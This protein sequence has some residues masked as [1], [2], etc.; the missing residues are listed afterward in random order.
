MICCASVVT[1]ERMR[2]QVEGDFRAIKPKPIRLPRTWPFE[3]QN[4]DC[5]ARIYKH[6]VSIKRK[7]KNQN[8]AAKTDEYETFL[9]AYYANGKRQRRRFMD[10]AKAK[11]EA[12]RITEQKAQGAL[13]AAA[14]SPAARVALENALA[15]LA[16]HEGTQ[17]AQPSR[18]VEIVNDYMAARAGLPEGATLT[19]AVK[20]FAA[21]HPANRPRKTVAE[22]AE[23]F[24]ADRR[25]AGCSEVHLHD[26]KTR[27]IRQFA[28]A[29]QLPITA[30]TAP[31]VREWVY[32]QK[33][34]RDNGPTSARNKENQLR[35]ISSM[36][37]FARRQ[38][39][40]PADLAL[41]IAE[42]PAP[43]KRPAP[44]GIY[45][46]GE[47]THIL[48]AADDEIKPALAIAAFAGLRLAE[49]SRLDWKE[50]RLA[51][52]LIVVE[53]GKAK[54][55]ARRLVPIAD[56]LAA[57]LAPHA[58]PF[59]PLNPCTE[60]LHCVGNALGNRFERAAARAKV[61]WKRNGF[62]HSFIS[63]RVAVLKDVPAVALESG[64]SPAVIFSHYRALLTE[65]EGKAWFD[66]MPPQEP[67]N[68]VPMPAAA[69]SASNT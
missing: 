64:N 11:A 60:E 48:A 43:K 34:K 57:W 68:V 10:F 55:A 18:L 28:P 13:G 46:A 32:G 67:G 41:E 52:R 62:R 63:T 56:N 16:K 7:K 2:T 40:V 51:E 12:E 15:Q 31:M 49:L 36:F 33:R 1:L 66:V 27:L 26:L 8:E 69:Q 20:D 65:A 59:G 21:R 9:L 29:F 42:I 44:I 5:V 50:V 23:E 6:T 4:G 3:V 61:A 17:A 24:I 22:V 25:S 30:V 38:K 45:N 54:T 37:Q 53:A 35:T 39:L 47:I 14:L 58:K 19:E